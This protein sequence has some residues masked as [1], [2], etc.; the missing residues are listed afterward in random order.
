MKKLTKKEKYFLNILFD[1]I[2][3]T[4]WDCRLS[5][6]Q[7]TMCKKLYPEAIVMKT[8]DKHKTEMVRFSLIDPKKYID[9]Y[10]ENLKEKVEMYSTALS[11]L[12]TQLYKLSDR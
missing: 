12:Q 11:E 5:Q 8:F 7:L 4:T 6:E 9:V 3:Y 10:I 1:E 2:S